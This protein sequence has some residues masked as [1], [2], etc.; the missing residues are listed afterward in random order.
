MREPQL[1][2][3]AHQRQH[4]K[5]ESRSK[6]HESIGLLECVDFAEFDKTPL[7]YLYC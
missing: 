3:V 7:K 4:Y 1:R 2:L 6:S 5:P